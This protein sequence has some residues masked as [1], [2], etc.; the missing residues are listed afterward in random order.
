MKIPEI[1]EAYRP[2]QQQY[3]GHKTSID[4]HLTREYLRQIRDVV[5]VQQL[6]IETLQ[7]RVATLENPAA[8]AVNPMYTPAIDAGQNPLSDV[9]V[10]KNK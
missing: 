2:T 5:A 4:A 1:P 3:H 8:A 10:K 9:K 7:N 6:L